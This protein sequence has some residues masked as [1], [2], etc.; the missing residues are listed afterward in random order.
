M[1]SKKPTPVKEQT[2]FTV[3]D[4]DNLE[5]YTNLTAEEVDT[6][7]RQVIDGEHERMSDADLI[8]VV[9]QKTGKPHT[10]DM[11]VEYDL[12]LD[13]TQP[14]FRAKTKTTDTETK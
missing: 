9:N 14:Q 1:P 4:F 10:V 2:L 5:V 6:T 11:R 8:S 13:T 7:I 3:I 12:T